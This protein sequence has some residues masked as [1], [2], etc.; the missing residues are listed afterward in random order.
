MNIILVKDYEE[1]SA[2]AAYLFVAQLINKPSSIL[3]LATGST[4]KGVYQNLVKFYRDGMIS[5]EKA[6]S[7]NLD[8]YLGIPKV[9]PQSYWSFM[10]N[11]FFKH[12]DMP[13]VSQYIPSGETLMP[14]Q[15]AQNYDA[16][17]RKAGGIDLQLLGIGRNGHIGFNEPNVKFEAKT[18]VVE[19]DQ[20][21]I[22]DNS[23]F[24]DH[25]EDVP[26]K[27]IS[28]G[29]KTIMQSKQIILLASGIEKSDAIYKMLYGNITPDVPASVLQLHP[30]VTLILDKEAASR[31]DLEYVRSEYTLLS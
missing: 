2:K 27:A 18:H 23:R 24:F 21:T 7:F 8:E 26:K 4:P 13:S 28:M 3:G 6:I 5:F 10:Q 9:H 1:M 14:Q 16:A 30:N 25:I 29:I 19:L 17:I 15:E 11:E 31:L 20:Q 12:V 22:Q